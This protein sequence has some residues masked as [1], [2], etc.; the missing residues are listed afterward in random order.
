MNDGLLIKGRFCSSEMKNRP[1]HTDTFTNETIFQL[2]RR[3]QSICPDKVQQT[4]SSTIDT[5]A[6]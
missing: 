4:V 2:A 3:H 5:W 6:S 1:F